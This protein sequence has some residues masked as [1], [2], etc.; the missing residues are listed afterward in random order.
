MK[1][2]LK[3][4]AYL[5]GVIAL[6]IIVL[7]S[8]IKLALPNVDPAPNL[9]VEITNEK[10]ERGKYL[11]NHVM[12]CVDC[13]STRDWSSFSGPLIK[14]T[15]GKGGEV[16]DQKLG[17]PGKYT[18]PNITPFHLK[19]WTDGEIFRAITSGVSKDGR[20]L[21]SIMPYQHYGQL[22]KNDIEAVIA[23]IRT[24]NPIEHEVEA[25]QSDFPMNF[26]I[27]TFPEKPE[28]SNTPQ[29]ADKINYG[30]YMITAAGCMDCHTK[31]D[32][33][34]F[35]G[36]FYAGGFDF[37]LSNGSMVT[38]A[39]ITPD[40]ATGI[41]NWTKEQFVERFKLYAN[42]YTNTKVNTGE[43]QTI[44]PWMMYSGMNTEDL[45]AIYAY[46]QTL[47]PVKNQINTATP[48]LN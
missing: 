33:G 32:K 38:S 24:L 18:A 1:K 36:E 30:K 47:P 35:V 8:Y 40:K 39:N 37:K 14:G 15:E 31:Q 43:F 4:L 2:I 23:Y 20:A 17:F 46:L 26:I 42:N 5:T 44:M 19:N 34:K 10:I 27:N 3:Y 16:F 12:L 11:A 21:F 48:H 13:H 41:G 29:H 9:K 45:E 7:L 28:F 25:P 6:V 22:D